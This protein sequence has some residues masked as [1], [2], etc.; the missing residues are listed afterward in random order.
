MILYCSLHSN[1]IF[2]PE[3]HILKSQMVPMLQQNPVFSPHPHRSASNTFFSSG[4]NI[5]V[6]LFS[7]TPNISLDLHQ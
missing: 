4:E 7:T 3:G 6:H 2:L 1:L 5:Y